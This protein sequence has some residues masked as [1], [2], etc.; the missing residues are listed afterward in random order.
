MAL[1]SRF[2]TTMPSS[3]SGM[4]RSSGTAACTVTA[5]RSDFAWAILAERMAS[6]V[7]LPVFKSV[8]TFMSLSSSSS[9]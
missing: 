3:V 2:P 9:I 5:M 8:S 1:S 4:V 6:S 7:T